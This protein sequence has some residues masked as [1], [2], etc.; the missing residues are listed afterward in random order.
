MKRII[1]FILVCILL[2]TRFVNLDWGLPYPM[3]PDERNMAIAIEGLRCDFSF[4]NFPYPVINLNFLKNC[5]NP[6]FFAYGQFSPY[7]GFFLIKIYHISIGKIDNSINFQEAVMSL[8]VISAF[9]S[10]LNVFILIKIIYFL[11]ENLKKSKPKINKIEKN[12]FLISYK[13]NPLMRIESFDSVSANDKLIIP[14]LIFIFSPFFIQFARFGTT[15]SLLMLFHSLIIYYSLQLFKTIKGKYIFLIS[16]FSG[17]AIATKI[18]SLIFIIT[19][20]FVVFLRI[21]MTS[22][23]IFK[24]SKKF[25]KFKEKF[26]DFLVYFFYVFIFLI[27]TALIA[28]LFSPHNLISFTDFLSSMRYESSVA[29]GTAK[30]F[31]TRQFDFTVP[32]LFQII[33]IFPYTLGWPIF[34]LAIMGIFVYLNEDEKYMKIIIFSFLVN[35]FSQAF[36][37]AKWTRF[38]TPVFPILVLFAVLFFLRLRLNN[39]LKALFLVLLITPGVAYLSIYQYPDVR[40]TASNWIYKNIPENSFLLFET[41]NVVD[42]PIPTDESKAQYKNYNGVSF[43]FYHIDSDQFLYQ[44]LEYYVKRADY[45]IVPSRRVFKNHYCDLKNERKQSIIS[46]QLNR[47]CFFLKEKYPLLNNYYENLFSGRL[48][49]EKVAE[50]NSFPRVIF[51]G[52]KILEFPD[53]DAEET[54]TVFDHPVIRIYKRV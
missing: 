4:K 20:L 50:F 25:I 43:N 8:R 5:F 33:K 26:S 38:M 29:L 23:I 9:A 40:F 16:L 27:L 44:A 14:F 42:V 7:L 31:Y 28:V 37:Y 53:E 41:A 47:K 11:I 48:G 18:S 22:K 21:L 34:I 12:I 13:K 10:V 49:F 19:P 3:H 1:F 24:S 30:V 17:L 32:I 36:L 2:Y 39:L 6:H 15:E 51:F 35:F 52:K 46:Q 54:W 45:I